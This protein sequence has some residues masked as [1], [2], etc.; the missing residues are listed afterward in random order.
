[1]SEQGGSG[2]RA[3][4]RESSAGPKTED[5]STSGGTDKGDTAEASEC[6]LSARQ[7]DKGEFVAEARERVF[8]CF[9]AVLGLSLNIC[10]LWLLSVHNLVLTQEN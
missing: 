9:L 7:E 8:V 1:M 6:E 2:K 10:F 4:Q 3:E 5:P